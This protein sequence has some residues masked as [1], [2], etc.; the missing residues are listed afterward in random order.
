MINLTFQFVQTVNRDGRVSIDEFIIN[1]MI[2]VTPNALLGIKSNA[3]RRKD[4]DMNIA[5][6]V[7]DI[8][9][10]RESFAGVYY[11][12][13][14]WITIRNKINTEQQLFLMSSPISERTLL[15]PSVEA[16]YYRPDIKLNRHLDLFLDNYP[17]I[18]SFYRAYRS[19]INET[20]VSVKSFH[21]WLPNINHDIRNHVFDFLRFQH[22]SKVLFLIPPTPPIFDLNIGLEYA[23]TAFII[24][25][26]FLGAVRT[27]N[28]LNQALEPICFFLPLSLN[29]FSTIEKA[30]MGTERLMKMLNELNPDI[31]I[32][33]IF[34]EVGKK[35]QNNEELKGLEYLMRSIIRYCKTNNK[36]SGILDSKEYGRILLYKGLNFVGVPLNRR[37]K[38]ISQ[39]GPKTGPPPK[40]E[41][42]I[43]NPETRDEIPFSNYQ[44]RFG[45]RR[46][47]GGIDAQN[48]P[49][50]YLG[51]L[52]N[53]YDRNRIQ[54][55]S[56]IEQIELS[57]ISPL[58][59]LAND[60]SELKQAIIEGNTRAIIGRFSR[61]VSNYA[62]KMR[63][64][65][66]ED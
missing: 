60:I 55:L 21:E 13:E 8:T 11:P 64:L 48:E 65:L 22:N 49:L 2:F 54:N 10:N 18:P 59:L 45:G 29:C 46:P 15:L 39:G 53:L 63:I 19:D 23:E 9:N 62:V 1:D 16:M 31:I 51:D 27:D 35:L 4:V 3:N 38:S 41:W 43:V 25:E 52:R 32:I 42:K 40:E 7:C 26:E 50:P 47:L 24:G 14:S 37:S 57:K 5:M 30:R 34:D 44:N 66:N 36:L 56:K 58:I 61:N 12:L 33:K 28:P 20:R 6:K 17:H